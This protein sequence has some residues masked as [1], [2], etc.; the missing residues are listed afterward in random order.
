MTR[1]G[2]LATGQRFRFADGGPVY[3]AR[4]GG[5]YSSPG[6]C[7]GGPWHRDAAAEVVALG[8]LL[9]HWCDEPSSGVLTYA[10]QEHEACPKHLR[11]YGRAPA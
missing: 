9:C 6:G 5:W 11:L 3:V 7:D 2:E 8:P 10:D 1:L 4:G